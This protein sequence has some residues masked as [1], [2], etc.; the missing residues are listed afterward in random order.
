MR[1]EN[2]IFSGF[3]VQG[4]RDSSGGDEIWIRGKVFFMTIVVRRK[5][6]RRRTLF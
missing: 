5:V 1:N 4:Q 6:S 2:E 3:V